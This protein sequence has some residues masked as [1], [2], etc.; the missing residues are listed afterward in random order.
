MIKHNSQSTTQQVSGVKA[1]KF[2]LNKSKEES[3]SDRF[4]T[5]LNND[6]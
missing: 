1:F 4:I 2:F 6:E 3:D 5:D